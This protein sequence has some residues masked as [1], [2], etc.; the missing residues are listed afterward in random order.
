MEERGAIAQLNKACLPLS[1]AIVVHSEPIEIYWSTFQTR[2]SHISTYLLP[3]SAFVYRMTSRNLYGKVEI[4][5]F[6]VNFFI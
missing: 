4:F 1:I 5:C 2:M 6:V 3:V